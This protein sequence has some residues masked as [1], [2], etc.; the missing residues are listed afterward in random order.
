MSTAQASPGV[1]RDAASGLAFVGCALM[2][3]APTDAQAPTPASA[4]SAQPERPRQAQATARGAEPSPARSRRREVVVSGKR[5]TTVD[6]HAHCSVP[7]AMALLS[8]PLPGPPALL[9]AKV[10]DRIH[11]MDAQGIDVEALSINPFWY[12][13]EREL[14]AQL[15][16]LQNEKLAEFCAAHKE[17]FV[18]FATV[19][20]QHPDLAVEQLV[21][22]VKTL[23]LRGVSVGG[24][25]NGEELA[26]EKFHPVWAKAEEL[27]VLVFLHPQGT[28]ELQ[29]R[30]GGNGGLDNA[31]GNPLE[32]TIALSHL[33]FEGTLDRFPGLKLCAAHGG[34]Y[35]PSYAARSDAIGVT[36]PERVKPLKKRPTEYLKQLYFDSIVFTPEALR[37]LAAETGPGQI[38]MGTDYPYPWTSTSVDHILATPGLSDEQRV[39]MLGGTAAKLLGIGEAVAR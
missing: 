4:A 19:A 29:G 36:F 3:A 31:I 1:A 35:L 2:N 34:G 28:A 15:I 18:A 5:V 26:A 37:H 22:G 30:L 17:R 23:G 24:S 8:S 14:A 32:T 33:I 11:A 10:E 21:Y 9:F 38:V 7:E 27:G 13:A 6:V 39:A 25:V 20:L 16:K 12:K